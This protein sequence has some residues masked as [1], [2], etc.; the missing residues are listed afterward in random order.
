LVLGRRQASRFELA[1][2]SRRRSGRNRISI[3]AP[4][5]CSLHRKLTGRRR[6]AFLQSAHTSNKP[7]DVYL[8]F[9]HGR[10]S[11]PAPGQTLMSSDW[12]AAAFQVASTVS[13]W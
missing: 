9:T 13:V 3:D 11:A 7:F 5:S 12:P 1:F 6:A 4:Q 8:P 10:P 2:R